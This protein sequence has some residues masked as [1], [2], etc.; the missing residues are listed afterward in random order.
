MVDGV[1][2]EDL[3][4]EFDKQ[5]ADLKKEMT[6]ISKVL[7]ERGSDTYERTREAASDAMERAKGQARGSFQ[8]AREQ[9][10]LVTDTVKENPGTAATVLSSAGVIGFVL[11]LVVGVAF[12][13]DSRRW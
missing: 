9:A 13:G 5:I 12:A 2:S 10:R 3:R 11:G 1:S 6:T 8:Q 7:A 4:K